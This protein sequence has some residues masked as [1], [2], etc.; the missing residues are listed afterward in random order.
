MSHEGAH[1]ELQPLRHTA[2]TRSESR[3]DPSHAAIRVTPRSESRRDPP[4]SES[5]CD[6]TYRGRRGARTHARTRTDAPPPAPVRA[7]TRAHPTSPFASPRAL[8]L[9]A[10]RRT[11]GPCAHT[12]AR[13]RA[14]TSACACARGCRTRARVRTEAPDGGAGRR[15]AWMDAWT[16]PSVSARPRARPFLV[17]R[18]RGA[19]SMTRISKG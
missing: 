15:R 16:P 3:R 13:T 7:R 18:P 2:M 10:G 19:A 5:R 17:S 12:R 11:R 8:A 1:V 6:P 14:R 9:L 4:R